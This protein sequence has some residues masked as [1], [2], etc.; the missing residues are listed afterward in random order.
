MQQHGVRVTRR[1]PAT[2]ERVFEAIV[3]PEAIVHWFA[4]ND[5][6]KVEAEV[7]ASIGGRYTVKMHHMFGNTYTAVGVFQSIEAPE[8]VVFT[9]SWLE[10][11]MNEI[12]E[13]RVTIEL[14]EIDG[15]TQLTLTHD[16]FPVQDAADRHK[17]GWNG[18][19]WR[20]ERQFGDSTLAS[21]SEIIALNRRLYN[22]ALDDISAESL[23]QRPGDA[24]NHMLWLAGHVAHNRATI[25]NLLGSDISSPLEVFNAPLDPDADYPSLE[26]IVEFHA[27]ATHALL[28]R[29]P[30]ADV[31]SLSADSPFPFELPV[32][33]NSVFGA[34]SFMAQ[35]EAYHV[36]QMGLLRKILGHEA[37]SYANKERIG[38]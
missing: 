15:G 29:L 2:R 27:Q 5:E 7:D 28:N 23:S 18:C 10:E 37:T 19:L 38:A 16:G 26:S 32:S 34:V 31:D 25:A 8:R 4:P 3:S 11:P 13:S 33:R 36:G 12:G 14:A 1:Y 9:W 22:N 17:E 30:L 21:V 35:H 6:M 20:L 24:A